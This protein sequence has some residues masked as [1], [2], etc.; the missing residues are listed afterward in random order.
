[1][2]RRST[3]STARQLEEPVFFVDRS[4]GRHAVADALRLVG[5]LVE[6]H[7][8]HFPTDTKDEVWIAEVGR[9][10]WIILTKDEAI[11]KRPQE[12]AA[13]KAFDA[14]VFALT[15]QDLSG[16]TMAAIFVKH[17]KRMKNLARSHP[18]PFW[19]TVTKTKVTVR[20]L[21]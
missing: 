4:L 11:R 3:T 21:Y 6:I 20:K 19:A 15:Y 8:D 13:V 1:M 17:L 18:H 10:G 2:K 14:C 5:L 12:L 7:D 16:P 9:R